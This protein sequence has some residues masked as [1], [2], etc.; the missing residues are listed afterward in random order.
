MLIE[1]TDLE[2]LHAIGQRFSGVSLEF[3]PKE[4][5]NKASPWIMPW[6][7]R[8]IADKNERD[9]YRITCYG[10]TAEEAIKNLRIA[11]AGKDYDKY[12]LP[13]AIGHWLGDSNE[14]NHRR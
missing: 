9:D 12:H 6:R 8:L 5:E 3:R 7:V 10:R 14:A 1:L 2:H 13:P 11:V 4:C